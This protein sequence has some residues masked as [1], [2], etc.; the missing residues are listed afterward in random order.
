MRRLRV[1]PAATL[2]AAVGY[3]TAVAVFDVAISG[4]AVLI[5]LLIFGPLLAALGS[6][7]RATAFVGA[8]AVALAIPLG[9]IDDIGGTLDHAIRVGVLATGSVVAVWFAHL[10][11]EREQ[12]LRRIAHV[13]EVAQR[14]ILRQPP[15]EIGSLSMAVRYLSATE[16]ALVGGDLYET[17]YTVAGVRLIVGDVRG[18][19]L[20]AVGVAASVLSTFR[21]FVH[22]AADLGDLARAIDGRLRGTIGAEEFVTAVLVEV[23]ERGDITIVNCGHHPPLRLTD[24]EHSFLVAGTSDLPLGMGPDCRSWPFEL[25]TGD[26]LLLYTDGLVEARDAAGREFDV[27]S[28]ADVLCGDDLGA[29]LDELLECVLA[30]VGQRLDDDLAVLLTERQER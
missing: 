7:A 17:A 13:A 8:Y 14:A 28:N 10:R 5:G 22:Q 29:S 24:R 4:R 9:F 3:L 30:H 18:K 26:R 12:A 2:P 15:P 11:V 19:G 1:P 23:P 6:S 21:E 27:L 25:A 20:D 16:E